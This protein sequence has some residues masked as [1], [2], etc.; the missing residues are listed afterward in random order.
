MPFLC[1]NITKNKVCVIHKD[2]PF[3]EKWQKVHGNVTHIA[4][5]LNSIEYKK[6]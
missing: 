1:T 2:T 3:S 5:L 6:L 4:N